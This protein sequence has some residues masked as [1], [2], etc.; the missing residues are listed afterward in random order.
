MVAAATAG[1]FLQ[2]SPGPASA[3][4]NGTLSNSVNGTHGQ[5]LRAHLSNVVNG[6]HG[7]K[8]LTGFSNVVNATAGKMINET[9]NSV[10]ADQMPAGCGPHRVCCMGLLGWIYGASALGAH[11]SYCCG[12]WGHQIICA[13]P[14]G[15]SGGGLPICIAPR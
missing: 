6:T 1:D 5:K 9:S 11:G 8:H 7:E 12:N 13:R 10:S 15:C 2:P 4:T 14:W 3:K